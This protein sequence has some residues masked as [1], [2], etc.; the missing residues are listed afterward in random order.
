LVAEPQTL[1]ANIGVI[2]D[3]L[4]FSRFGDKYGID[5]STMHNTGADFKSTGSQWRPPTTQEIAYMTGLLDTI[6]NQFHTVVT[7]S[8]GARIKAPLPQVFN[9]QAYMAD[10]ALKM[11][12]ID[13]TGYQDDACT[14]A[15][16]K[17]GLTKPTV[18]KYEQ[19]FSL[20]TLLSSMSGKSNLP[21]HEASSGL[22]I[23]GMSVESP[24][25][26]EWLN[27]KPLYLYRPN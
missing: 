3:T 23:N 26:D 17:A 8:R 12:L 21:G 11:G 15:A 7:T 5:D 9:A 22:K 1:T 20:A 16:T 6:A 18:V 27:P 2:Q 25:L 14:Y 4:N 24:Q 19:P 10:A 13:Q